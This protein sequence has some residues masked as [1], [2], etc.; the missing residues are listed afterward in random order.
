[1]LRVLADKGIAIAKNVE[2]GALMIAV[3]ALW[4]GLNAIIFSVCLIRQ[5]FA[6]VKDR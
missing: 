2:E 1:M 6:P 4:V 3:G 5:M